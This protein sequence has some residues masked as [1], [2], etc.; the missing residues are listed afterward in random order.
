M[1]DL[2][3]YTS[4]DGKSR[5]QLRASAAFKKRSNDAWTP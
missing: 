2:I 3:L 1:S 5:I 4:K